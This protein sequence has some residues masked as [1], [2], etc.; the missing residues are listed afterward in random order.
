LEPTQGL[1]RHKIALLV[2]FDNVVLGIDD[3]GFDV[4]IVV[5]AL[6][7]RGVVVLGRAYGDWYR[8]NRHRR[9]LMEQGIDLIETPVF[10]PIIKNSADMH[11]ALDAFEMAMTQPHI[12][13]YC[14]VSGDSDFLPL[15][16]RLQCRDKN[17]IVIAGHKFT[18]ELVRRNCNE[19]ISYEN[20][21]AQSVGATEDVTT[22]EGAFQLLERTINT[23]Q[24]R[25]MD[26]RTSTVKQ[27][28]L[29]LNPAFSERYF[30][31]NQFKHFLDRACRANIIKTGRR[32]PI[33]GEFA[34]LLP[35]D[36]EPEFE[37]SEIKVELNGPSE[38]RPVEAR[39]GGESRNGN[40]RR[41]ERRNAP[42]PAEETPGTEA[43]QETIEAAPE[44][45]LADEVPQVEKPRSEFVDTGSSLGRVPLR[46]GRLRFS[47]KS[48]RTVTRSTGKSEETAEI[49][50]VTNDQISSTPEQETAELTETSAV[51]EETQVETAPGTFAHDAVTPEA[52]TEEIPSDQLDADA[53]PATEAVA[54]AAPVAE[55]EAPAKK[56]RTT[57][58][59]KKKTPEAEPQ[60]AETAP[61][62]D[63]AHEA[64]AASETA[65]VEAATET[66]PAEPQSAV[67][68]T[69]EAEIPAVQTE[70]QPEAAAEGEASGE[71]EAP[72]PKRRVVRRRPSPRRG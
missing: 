58:S 13:T 47:A 17:V 22:I 33:S 56:K 57:R 1:Q 28:M 34:V 18:S 36:V 55:P 24:E 54:E 32:D 70:A 7:A 37:N 44:S 50:A 29:Q 12:D 71:E 10:G 39:N 69:S 49:A 45:T 59:R 3:P 68:T 8:H 16:K 25:S 40:R 48:G 4:E 42:T 19:Y 2:D 15:I 11:M 53:E 26:V 35:G 46:R 51:V 23:L 61:A 66:A 67:A 9:K 41:N 31:C 52:A 14:I 43:S 64:S 72:K 6:R 30:G 62:P 27:M 63:A 60:N 21:L 65:P 5:N 20:L 38:V